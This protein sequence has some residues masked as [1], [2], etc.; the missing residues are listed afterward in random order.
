MGNLPTMCWMQNIVGKRVKVARLSATPQITQ[1]SLATI[2]QL[3]GWEIQRSGVAKIEAGIRQVTDKEVLHLAK[4]LK[5]K[6]EWLYE[7]DA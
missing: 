2:L 7:E 4:A 1:E 6:V 3:N 5:V